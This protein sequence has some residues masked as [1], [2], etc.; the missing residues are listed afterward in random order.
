MT[1]CYP[2]T[3]VRCTETLYRS[4]IVVST[5]LCHVNELHM[6]TH[7]YIYVYVFDKE[8]RAHFNVMRD[9]SRKWALHEWKWFFLSSSFALFLLLFLFLA[10]YP[11][12]LSSSDAVKFYK[13]VVWIQ[14]ERKSKPFG[15]ICAKNFWLCES[16]SRSNMNREHVKLVGLCE[17]KSQQ[18]YS[19][20]KV[21][22]QQFA[23]YHC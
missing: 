12:K 10:W 22:V 2:I 9:F 6:H 1:S 8:K 11:I 19:R 15:D 14:F 5:C 4:R 20:C 7:T 17:R 21:C 18:D 23:F 16:R 13:I 3:S